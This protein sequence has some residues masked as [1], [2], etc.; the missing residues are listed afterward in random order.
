MTHFVPSTLVAIFQDGTVPD[1]EDA[2][3]NPVPVGEP[4]AEQA[5]VR[6][7]PA[8]LTEYGQSGQSGSTTGQPN[9]GD[10]TVVHK[11]RLRMRPRATLGLDITNRTRVLDQ[12]TGRYYGVD[13]TPLSSSTAEVGDVRLVLHRVS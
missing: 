6:D 8:L 10:E 12:R 9:A 7:V 3:G 4:T 11:F 5:D 13:E 1:G 2:W